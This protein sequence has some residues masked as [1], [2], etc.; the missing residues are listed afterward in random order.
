MLKKSCDFDNTKKSSN[1]N[2]IFKKC[3]KVQRDLKIKLNKKY[4]WK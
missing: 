3:T 1:N 4:V 2:S